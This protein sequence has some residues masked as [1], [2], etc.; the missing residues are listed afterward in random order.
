MSHYLSNKHSIPGNFFPSKNSSDAPPPVE[1]C[2][3]LS[4][5][6]AFSTAAPESPPPIIVVASNSD[7]AFAISFVPIANW[8]NSNNPSGPFQITVFAFFSSSRARSY[9][10]LA[11]SSMLPAIRLL[12]P[13]LYFYKMALY[14]PS[15]YIFH[16]QYV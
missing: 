12:H 16:N 10:Y 8:S 14:L 3:I 9:L 2:V 5:N 7:K 15:L 6:P 13:F 11:N 4:P 1:M